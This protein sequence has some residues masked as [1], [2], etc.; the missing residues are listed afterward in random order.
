M[1]CDHCGTN[2]EFKVIR[3]DREKMCFACFLKYYPEVAKMAMEYLTGYRSLF[4]G[5]LF[6]TCYALQ[7][8]CRE[9]A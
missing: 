4:V 9:V 3:N 2:P 8:P 1:T 6:P 7:K 5:K